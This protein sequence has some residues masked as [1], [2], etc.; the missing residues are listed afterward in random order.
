MGPTVVR[1]LGVLIAGAALL[2]ACL[3]FGPAPVAAH[4]P[5]ALTHPLV[6][7]YYYLWNPE[8]MA[9]GTLRAHLDP[10]QQ[11]PAGLVDSQNPKTAARPPAPPHTG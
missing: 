7:A 5:R 11:P 10:P 8:N 6:G 9:T 4:A 1:R 2:G 3:S